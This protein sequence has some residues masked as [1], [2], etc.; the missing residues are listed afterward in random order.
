MSDIDFTD[1]EAVETLHRRAGELLHEIEELFKPGMK[2]TLIA[3][4]PAHPDGTQNVVLSNE[5]TLPD[6]L[7]ALE[8]FIG[9]PDVIH[10]PS[11]AERLR[12][13]EAN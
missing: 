12:K 3:R 5:S 11:E 10:R 2:L 9:D 13:R 4:N 7:R 1:E 8:L 6:A